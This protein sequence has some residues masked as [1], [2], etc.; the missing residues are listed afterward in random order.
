M[1]PNYIKKMV[2]NVKGTSMARIP[3]E[4]V[5]G[6]ITLKP[7]PEYNKK[8]SRHPWSSSHCSL[9]PQVVLYLHQL[10]F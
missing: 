3:M 5:K 10:P 6:S 4:M 8:G 2:K 7:K 9:F 1:C